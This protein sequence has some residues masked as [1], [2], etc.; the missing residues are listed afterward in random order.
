M[1]SFS[2][3]CHCTHT[4][5]WS[6]LEI[7]GLTENIF[8]ILP[9]KTWSVPFFRIY[10]VYLKLKKM[11]QV[12]SLVRSPHGDMDEKNNKRVAT[13]YYGISCP[14]YGQFVQVA[15]IVYMQLPVLEWS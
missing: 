10:S 15:Q 5:I 11:S 8:S 12:V 14:Q 7:W 4:F 1:F 2:Y 9:N 13:H 3:Y 6:I